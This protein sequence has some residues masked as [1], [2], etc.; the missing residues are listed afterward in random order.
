MKPWGDFKG[1]A[2]ITGNTIV[3][4][5]SE[6]TPAIA[7]EFASL[8]DQVEVPA[9][10]FN[11]VG[12]SGASVGN[13]LTTS[14]KINMVSMTGSVKAG[15]AIMAAA[16]PN[17]TRVNI[18]LGGKAPAIV[19]DDGNLDLAAEAIWNSRV[20]NTGQV[21]NCAEV[22][23]VQESVHDELVAKLKAKFE[24]TR[25]DDPSKNSEIDMGP[26]INKAAS[27]KVQGMVDR[28]LSEGATLV[29]G[30]QAPEGFEEGNFYQ[31]TIITDVK[32]D[33]E[34]ARDEIFGPVLPMVK[35]RDLDE[36]LEIANSSKYG[37]TS[38]VY[39]ENLNLAMKASRELL[40]GETYINRENFEAMQG[41]HAGRRQSGIGGADGK[42]GLMEFVETHTVY[43]QSQL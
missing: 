31:P 7:F 11:M 15:K 39:T 8:V 24:A 6:E 16:A 12:G 33:S 21:C 32:A 35:V 18:E 4:K 23:L 41:F 19:L 10:V 22:V 27:E 25:F 29:T 20:I 30:G 1:V 40:Y 5:P 34:I 42:H 2:A 37:L 9:G 13:A 26:L 14:P 38:S 3:I 17:L 36:A 28:A 43:I